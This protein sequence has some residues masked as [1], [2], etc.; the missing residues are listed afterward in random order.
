M[1]LSLDRLC[2]NGLML[3][4]TTHS[5]QAGT[6]VSPTASF[7]FGSAG[8]AVGVRFVCPVTAGLKD[9]YYFIMSITGTAANITQTVQV[10]PADASMTKPSSGT[11]ITNGD[12]DVSLSG[13]SANTW[14]KATFASVV[15]L[16]QGESYW[17][18]IHDT[19][20]SVPATDYAEVAH[21][22]GPQ[23]VGSQYLNFRSVITANGWS[24]GT[25]QTRTGVMVLVFDD[26]TVIGNPYTTFG[27]GTANNLERGWKFTPDE[28]LIVSGVHWNLLDTDL[29]F[30][31]IYSGAANP[32]SPDNSYAITT[33]SNQA[34]WIRIP[35]TTC[36]KGVVCR[37]T[38]DSSGGT[39]NDP[40]F[41]EIQDSNADL[42]SCGFMGGGLTFCIDNGAGGWTDSANK[43]AQ[44]GILISG[45]PAIAGGGLS[46]RANII[47]NIGT[48]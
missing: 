1:A 38:V 6:D 40:N 20:T 9:V 17:I 15:S 43:C 3:G 18:S 10:L 33:A 27:F 47:Q 35:P 30:V 26:G 11:P 41:F 44:G 28:D 39:S 48:Y 7:V 29:D 31:R 8:D 2:A 25:G 14:Q 21:R 4:V 23:V 13:V 34:G 42:E 19:E 37:I 5:T 45:L 24:T 12:K 46:A 16:T 22:G 32:G 36:A